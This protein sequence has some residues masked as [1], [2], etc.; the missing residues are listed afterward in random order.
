MRIAALIACAPLTVWA[1]APVKPKTGA[2]LCVLTPAD[3]KSVGVANADKPKANVSDQGASAYCVYAGKSGA[4]GGIELDVFD[5]TEPDSTLDTASSEVT[6]KWKPI[7]VGSA[8][9]AKWAPDAKSGGPEFAVLIAQRGSVV[10][11]LAIP[12]A[13]D[14]EQRLT[15]LGGIV[16]DRLA[17]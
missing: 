8:K 13:K 10:F 15:K 7:K 14:S 11:L 5:P 4:T 1:D 6:A 9:A 16:L 3:F 12:P 17:P 2:S